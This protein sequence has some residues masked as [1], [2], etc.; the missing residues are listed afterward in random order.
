MAW[1]GSYETVKYAQIKD[2]RLG[3]LRLLL[4]LTI[5]S[6]IVIVEM[7]Q[8]GGYSESNSVV[9]VVRFSLQQPTHNDCD[10]S[11]EGCQNAF[12]PL[13][14]LEYC[15]QATGY[16]TEYAGNVYPCQ[17]YEAVNAEIVRETSLIIWT[18][19]SIYNQSLVCDDSI[20]SRSMACPNTYEN[21]E[22]SSQPFYIA[23]SEA[24][25]ILLD[26]A[27]TASR[28]CEH[29]GHRNS[30]KKQ[31][32][33]CSA[34]S[35]QYQGRLYST[36]EGLCRE[37]F[38]KDNSFAQPQ[39]STLQSDAPCFIG[40]NR[41]SKNLDFFSLHV[42]MQ[43][44]GVSLDD[45]MDDNM[46]NT[47][48]ITF[49][50]SG[51]TLLLNVVWNDF[52]SFQGLVEPFYYYSPQIIGTS[53]KESVPFYHSYRTSRTLMRAHGIKIAVTLNGDFHQFQFLT[54]LITLTTA[55]GLF[56]I[57]T[58]IIDSLM[59]YVLP[60]KKH[61]QQV[62]YEI[63]EGESMEISSQDCHTCPHNDNLESTS[64]L[65]NEDS[66]DEERKIDMLNHNIL[67]PW[68][69]NSNEPLLPKESDVISV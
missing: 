62:K 56:A 54:L 46:N 45:C 60:E 11:S 38:S 67:I 29:H 44:A 21:Q 12:K 16:H 36:Y 59:L 64:V 37:E 55:L 39:G 18:R 4:L 22:P 40:S 33:A 34:Q 49:R 15:Q 8:L 57:A 68:S 65:S 43:A 5:A 26:H 69:N 63:V 24:F 28:I 7:C 2:T 19:A 30:K 20:E 48:C 6:Y 52:R 27:V 13:N 53:Y 9:G 23:Q 32:Y 17:I 10:P 66:G 61:Y 1:F 58:A 25:T 50:E 31:H 41:T 3:A 42:L 14:E 35:S 47:N 51:A